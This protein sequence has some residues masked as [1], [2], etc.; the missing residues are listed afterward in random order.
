MSLDSKFP[1]ITNIKF[2]IYLLNFW[3]V[4]SNNN[5]ICIEK[6]RYI[7]INDYEYSNTK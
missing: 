3:N 5:S 6:F 2:I 4:F 1:I 7:I